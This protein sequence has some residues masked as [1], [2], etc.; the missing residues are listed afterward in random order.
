MTEFTWTPP[1]DPD[2]SEILHSAVDDTRHGRYIESLEKHLWYH[3]NAM[4]NPLS[5]QGGVRLSFALGYWQELAKVYPPA[6]EAFVKTRNEAEAA[7]R[8]T[9]QFEPFHDVAAF[10]RELGENGRTVDLFLEIAEKNFT[11]AKLLYIVAEQYLIAAKRYRECN[12]FLETKQRMETAARGYEIES[13]FIHRRSNRSGPTRPVVSLP[14][15]NHLLSLIALLVLND[16]HEEAEEV[17]IAALKFIDDEHFRESLL[18]A[19]AGRF[20]PGF[21]K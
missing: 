17:Q 11:A 13:R 9:H 12:P 3:H 16:R 21:Q 15:V 10:N 14:T 7:V 18:E 1:D 19:M 2:P 8:Q 20:P 4:N 6:K 5:G